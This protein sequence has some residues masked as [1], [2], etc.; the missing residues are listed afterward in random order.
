MIQVASLFKSMLLVA[1]RDVERISG[2]DLNGFRGGD[3]GT[4]RL[5]AFILNH[6]PHGATLLNLDLL[7]KALDLRN[8]LAH[9]NGLL[10]FARNGAHLRIVVEKQLYLPKQRRSFTRDPNTDYTVKIV[11]TDTGERIVVPTYY[12]FWLCATA[13]DLLLGC[14]AEAIWPDAFPDE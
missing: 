7:E 4:R 1:C 3:R 13:G 10:T 9:A 8:C 11:A 14:C 6:L 2:V 12:S 5:A